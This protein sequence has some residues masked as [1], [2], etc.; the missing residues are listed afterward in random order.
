MLLSLTHSRKKAH[1]QRKF[2]HFTF[3]AA[4]CEKIC[5]V[6]RREFRWG[7]GLENEGMLWR[8]EQ[9]GEEKD[10]IRH[11]LNLKITHSSAS[12][13]GGSFRGTC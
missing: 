5:N 13:E 6:S 4:L 12:A 2:H 8:G 3:F 10:I 11:V 9:L 7:R 1:S